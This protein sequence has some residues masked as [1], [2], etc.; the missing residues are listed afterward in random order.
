MEMSGLVQWPKQRHLLPFET[1]GWSP[2][3]PAAGPEGQGSPSLW[4]DTCLPGP[5]GGLGCPCPAPRASP[6]GHSPWPHARPLGPS[7]SA[8]AMP[9]QGCVSSS[10]SPA[11]P[12]CRPC[13]AMGPCPSQASAGPPSPGTCPTPGARAA[14]V[15]PAALLL[16]GGE[17][18][19]ACWALPWSPLAVVP[20]HHQRCVNLWDTLKQRRCHQRPVFRQRDQA[21]GIP[22]AREQVH[23]C[24]AQH[25]L[26]LSRV[27]PNLGAVEA[28]SGLP[29][30]PASQQVPP[31][32]RPCLKSWQLLVLQRS[33]KPLED[34]ILIVDRAA[35]GAGTC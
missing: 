25:W 19:P 21:P 20:R 13:W 7:A 3:L 24:E 6:P 11:L 18:G 34:K 1:L 26:P 29:L 33:L 31:E 2:C 9:Q 23:S 8:P 35:C 30:C 10:H 12:A 32:E 27:D 5:W 17:T 4:G 14:S 16:A 22:R 28:H 15:P